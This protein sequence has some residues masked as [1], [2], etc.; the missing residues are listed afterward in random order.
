MGLRRLTDGDLKGGFDRETT[1]GLLEDT[2]FLRIKCQDLSPAR[3]AITITL[4]NYFTSAQYGK[5][6]SWGR[7]HWIFH[8]ESWALAKYVAYVDSLRQSFKLGRS[9][10]KAVWIVVHHLQNLYRSGHYEAIRD[11][12]GDTDTKV[13]Y[14]QNAREIEESAKE[15][16]LHNSLISLIPKLN[17]GTAIWTVGKQH[18]I[19]VRHDVWPELLPLVET[20]QRAKGEE[21]DT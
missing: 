14:R 5:Q 4:V 9:E 17:A 12:I 6:N 21:I 16:E 18:G 8:D 2:P 11:L 20:S 7:F 15:L 13:I 1:A 19:P 10:G 3:A